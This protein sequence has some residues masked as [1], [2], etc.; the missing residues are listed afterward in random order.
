MGAPSE[1]VIIVETR[2]AL[3]PLDV[4]SIVGYDGVANTEN[5]LAEMQ[6]SMKED[7]YQVF[8][9]RHGGAAAFVASYLAWNT[10]AEDF[11]GEVE[12]RYD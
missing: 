7:R 8:K 10:S 9:D 6:V 1:S 11:F 5:V 12:R 4:L 2:R 3:T